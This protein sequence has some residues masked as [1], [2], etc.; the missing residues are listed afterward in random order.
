MAKTTKPYRPEIAVFEL[1]T[2]GQFQAECPSCALEV[3]R[4]TPASVQRA[5]VK[6]GADYGHPWSQ[7]PKF[8]D[9]PYKV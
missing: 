8:T 4:A 6:H 1:I 9:G 5:M 3:A 7:R 2:G